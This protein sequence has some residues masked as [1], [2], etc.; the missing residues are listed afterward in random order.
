M[1]HSIKTLIGTLCLSLGFLSLGFL[2]ALTSAKAQQSHW[3][4]EK[5]ITVIV[6]Y[7]PGGATDVVTRIVM[8]QLSHRLGQNI[9]IDNRP[10]ANATIGTAQLARAPADGYHFVT[11][12]AAHSVNPHLYQLPYS[13]DDFATITQMAELPMFLFVSNQLP[14]NSV[15]ELVAY[16]KQHTLNFAS[17]GTGSS[18]HMIGLHFANVTGLKM[19]HIPYRGSAPIL[20]DLLA[21][22]VSLAF[23]PILVPMPYVKEDRLKVLALSAKSKWPDEPSI[24]LMSELGY[25]NFDLSSWVALLGP[26]GT[27]QEIIDRLA[28]EIA[29]ILQ[30]NEVKRK[31]ALAGFI[32]KAGSPAALSELIATDSATYKKI[33]DK[34]DIHID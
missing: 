25:E 16:G 27:P 28:T 13:Q 4:H 12:I 7:T 20:S 9:V 18:A 30:D 6:P 3:P 34:N 11:V 32:P 14:V 2:G 19:T 22:R 33:I 15:E 5:A 31:F 24:P 17:S 23:D 26:S 10:G 29:D 8:E 21:G 1:K